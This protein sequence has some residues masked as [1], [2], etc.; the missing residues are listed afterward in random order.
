MPLITFE[1][2]PSGAAAIIGD[3]LIGVTPVQANIPAGDIEVT[4]WK[5]GFEIQMYRT[6]V[7]GDGKV[8]AT[9]S[10]DASVPAPPLLSTNEG[11]K[12][13]TN[14]PAKGGGGK[15]GKV[16]LGVLALGATGA[17]A[18]WLWRRHKRQRG[19]SFHGSRKK[20]VGNGTTRISG[21]GATEVTC[22]A[23][24]AGNPYGVRTCITRPKTPGPVVTSPSA[25]CKLLKA[26]KDADRESFFTV[27]LNARGNVI[28]VEETAKGDVSGV[29]V[30]PREV[31]K[32]PL[33]LGASMVVVAHNHPS[34]DPVPSAED[35][36][37]TKRLVK[38]GKLVG[39]PVVDHIV[40]GEHC[41]SL[42]E[43]W[44]EL[45]KDVGDY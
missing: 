27:S 3:Q 26:A 39:V 5:K 41:E 40:V 9:L 24:T 31:F 16:I 30:H 23:R 38:A 19:S 21:L 1:T 11:S 13:P 12:I 4:F 44:P 6:V 36:D 34:G 28:G 20:P 18:W 17:G 10:E 42:A 33:I 8:G 32:S 43:R 15:V 37:L 22:D 7:H 29:N 35:K 25:V 14:Q 45:F 2:T